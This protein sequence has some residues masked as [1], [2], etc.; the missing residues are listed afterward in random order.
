MQ[1][2]LFTK[3]T[4][5]QIDAVERTQRAH[6]IRTILEHARR[7]DGRRRDK[8]LRER[9]TGRNIIIELF[10]ED[11]PRFAQRLFP[12]TPTLLQPRPE[13]VKSV[14]RARII[15]VVRRNQRGVQRSRPRGMKHLKDIA[16]LIA[17]PIKDSINPKILSAHIR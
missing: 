11:A 9:M 6:R 1:R 17:I 14:H 4:D 16:G 13:V 12:V 2:P 15:D 5:I 10:V 3:Q 8:E 7:I